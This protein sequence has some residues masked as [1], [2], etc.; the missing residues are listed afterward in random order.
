MSRA[1]RVPMH[2]RKRGSS[3]FTAFFQVTNNGLKSYIE[4]LNYLSNSIFYP[5]ILSKKNSSTCGI[6]CMASI[7]RM[8]QSLTIILCFSLTEIEI[9]VSTNMNCIWLLL[10]FYTPQLLYSNSDKWKWH[11]GKTPYYTMVT[12]KWM[13]DN[14]VSYTFIHVFDALSVLWRYNAKLHLN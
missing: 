10:P 13:P 9:K 6:L 3:P 1:S 7:T 11:F 5:K 8:F 2:P 4:H 14:I 12:L